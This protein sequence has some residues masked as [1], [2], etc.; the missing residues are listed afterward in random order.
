LHKIL[1]ISY[2]LITVLASWSLVNAE[3]S[4]SLVLRIV[5]RQVEQFFPS[6]RIELA[7]DEQ[8]DRLPLVTDVESVEPHEMVL[9]QDAQD[10]LKAEILRV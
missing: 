3:L 2:K 9:P 8:R 10:L 7:M 5:G 1:L 6:L 4:L